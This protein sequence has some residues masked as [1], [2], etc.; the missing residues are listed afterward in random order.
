MYHFVSVTD[1]DGTADT[2][3]L[4][5]NNIEGGGLLFFDANLDGD[6]DGVL[7][8]ENVTSFAGGWIA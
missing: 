5:P 2:G 4:G 1:F 6:I 7:I 8:L 3:Q